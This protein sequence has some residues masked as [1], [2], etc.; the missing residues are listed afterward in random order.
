MHHR[1]LFYERDIYHRAIILIRTIM[2]A[3]LQ[4]EVDQEPVSEAGRCAARERRV[5]GEPGDR[6]DRRCSG[7]V[8][9]AGVA[10]PGHISSGSS[11]GL[12]SM[13]PDGIELAWEQR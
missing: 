3:F 1:P 9:G 11:H 12:A 10:D 4:S 6:R 5:V 2:V 8:H 7:I 13:I